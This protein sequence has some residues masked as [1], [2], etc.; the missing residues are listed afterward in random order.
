MKCVIDCTASEGNLAA[1]CLENDI[2]YLGFCFTEAHRDALKR[3]LAQVVFMKFMDKNSKL[4]VPALIT[5]PEATTKPADDPTPKLNTKPGPKKAAEGTTEGAAVGKAVGDAVG[6][7]VGAADGD[8]VGASV[9][10]A[11]GEAV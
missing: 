9:G 5:T 4:A 7:R 6:C 8:A 3:R 10:L 1:V 11:V 2:P